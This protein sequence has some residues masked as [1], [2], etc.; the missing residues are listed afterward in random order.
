MKREDRAAV[1]LNERC[2]Y[3][4]TF[5]YFDVSGNGE[6]SADGEYVCGKCVD[7]LDG[8]RVA[9]HHE[10]MRFLKDP[11]EIYRL[12]R[13]VRDLE[14]IVATFAEKAAA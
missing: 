12:E 8:K 2:C 14:T 10:L 7:R 6:E 3:C 4:L 11:D 9:K 5:H 1:A 13:R